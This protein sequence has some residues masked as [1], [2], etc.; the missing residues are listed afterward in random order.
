MLRFHYE[1]FVSVARCSWVSADLLDFNDGSF[2][3]ASE[4]PTILYLVSDGPSLSPLVYTPAPSP[5]LSATVTVTPTASLSFGQ[6]ASRSR[7]RPPAQESSSSSPSPPLQSS[8]SAS[9]AAGVSRSRSATATATASL[10]GGDNAAASPAASRAASGLSGAATAG[11][12]VAVVLAT[13]V[14]AAIA[15][16]VSRRRRQR[17]QRAKESLVVAAV[18][19]TGAAVRAGKGGDVTAVVLPQR[20]SADADPVTRRSRTPSVTVAARLSAWIARR[21]RARAASR[22]DVVLVGRDRNDATARLL[23][24]SARG[25]SGGRYGN[26]GVG[27]SGSSGSGVVAEAE[28]GGHGAAAAP[29]QLLLASPL[30]ETQGGSTA[31]TVSVPHSATVAGGGLCDNSELPGGVDAHRHIHDA[32]RGGDSGRRRHRHRHGDDSDERRHR[33]SGGHGDGGD[34]DDCDS[35]HSRHRRS[36]SRHQRRSHRRRPPSSSG[37]GK[38]ED[39]VADVSS[40]AYDDTALR[41]TVSDTTAATA[42]SAETAEPGSADPGSG[43]AWTSVGADAPSLSAPSTS[44]TR[45][46]NS[47]AA[48]PTSAGDDVDGPAA[49]ASHRYDAAVSE[50]RR[51][52][53]RSS[54]VRRKRRSATVEPRRTVPVIGG[55]VVVTVVPGQRVYQVSVSPDA[56]VDR[57][58]VVHPSPRQRWSR[59]PQA[60]QPRRTDVD[61]PSDGGDVSVYGRQ[62][63]ALPS[64]PGTQRQGVWARRTDVD[65]QPR[66]SHSRDERG[67]RRHRHRHRGSEPGDAASEPAATADVTRLKDESVAVLQRARHMLSWLSH[68]DRLRAPGAAEPVG[69]GGSRMLSPRTSSTLRESFPW[70]PDEP[71]GAAASTAADDGGGDDAQDATTSS[72]AR[73][74]YF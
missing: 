54:S 38:D 26:S 36:S 45:D 28:M 30:S 64:P 74:W 44:L 11:V 51:V 33:R 24:S 55:G 23:A 70:L 21:R 49:S 29:L 34:G 13:A 15:V 68:G 16:A 25:D 9:A 56:D 59:N 60:A 58:A 22:D 12:V 27:G 2:F 5:S 39:V 14:C 1:T 10:P 18:D 61:G 19:D 72:H 66:R 57:A 50:H 53:N 46:S 17:S 47:G 73:K 63:D 6:S 43:A 37:R 4:R 20:G 42:A 62:S 32:R 48:A 3:N 41:A 7:S 69:D 35:G 8:A 71:G 67:H 40:R 31:A 52:A 65:A